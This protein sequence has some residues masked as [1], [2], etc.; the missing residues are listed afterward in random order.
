MSQSD[1]SRLKER[2]LA[3]ITPCAGCVWTG[4]RRR[5]RERLNVYILAAAVMQQ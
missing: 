5:P 1:K 4:G 3:R 2:T